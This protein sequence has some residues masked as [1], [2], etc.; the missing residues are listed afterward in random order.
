MHGVRA[1]VASVSFMG[2]GHKA[3]SA[4]VT[5][6]NQ[7][8]QQQGVQRSGSSACWCNLIEGIVCL[9]VLCTVLFV[10]ASQSVKSAWSS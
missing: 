6:D 4:C 8:L 5:K 10:S 7:R 1:S 9:Q 3:P 2:E